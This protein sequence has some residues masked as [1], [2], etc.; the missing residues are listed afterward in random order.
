MSDNDS[1][2]NQMNRGMYLAP[3]LIDDNDDDESPLLKQA[4]SEVADIAERSEPKNK[5]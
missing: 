4:R 1:V 3:S 5:P 2:A